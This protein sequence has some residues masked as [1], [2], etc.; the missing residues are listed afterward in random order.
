[1]TFTEEQVTAVIREI[2]A[3]RPDYVYDSPSGDAQCVYG[4][5]DGNPSCLVGHV[6]AKLDPEGFKELIGFANELAFVS[7]DWFDRPPEDVA[8]ALLQAQITQDSGRP[9]AEALFQYES[10]LGY[11]D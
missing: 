8:S 3:E 9:W 6:I 11:H 5:A 4:D 2:V 7:T 10:T 1:M